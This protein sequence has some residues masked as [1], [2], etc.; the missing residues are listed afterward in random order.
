MP[1]PAVLFLA[2]LCIT[3]SCVTTFHP[4]RDKPICQ[5]IT[6]DGSPIHFTID[7]QFSSSESRAIKDAMAMFTADTSGQIIFRSGGFK[8]V[9]MRAA[10]RKDIPCQ[11]SDNTIGC[12]MSTGQVDAIWLVGD[13]I[14]N[15]AEMRAVVVH[16]LLHSMGLGHSTAPGSCMHENVDAVCIS[17]GHIPAVDIASLCKIGK[18]RCDCH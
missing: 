15:D 12:H 7:N 9:F 8:L 2:I 13:F 5:P 3:L 11:G 10:S 17:S 1:K 4:P 6:F 18:I 14:Y 16:E